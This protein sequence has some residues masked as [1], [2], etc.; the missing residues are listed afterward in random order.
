MQGFYVTA[1]LIGLGF[2][3]MG[4][5]DPL[6]DSFVPL[7][8]GDYI[9]SKGL[10]GT[11]MTL[12]NLFALFLIPFVSALSDRTRTSIGRRMPW[13]VVTLPLTAI[14]FATVPFAAGISLAALIASLF[15]LN[16]FK[17]AARGPVVALMPDTI[18]GE[19]RSEA[20]G[21]INTMAG[22]AAIVGTVGLSKLMDVS[23][24]LPLVGNTSRRLPFLLAGVLVVIATVLLFVFIKE[25]SR[26]GGSER[27]EPVL[28]SIRAVLTGGDESAIFILPALLFWFFG[29]Q[30]I[31]PFLTMYTRDFLGVSEGTAGLSPGMFAVSYAIFAI[32]SGIVA[33]RAGRGRT[34]RFS[35]LVISVVCLLLFAHEPASKLL[36]F[37][38]NAALAS[39]WGLLFAMGAFW[40]A[41]VTNSFPMLWQM[42]TYETMG[43][44]TG[45]YYTFSQ[46][47]AILSPPVTGTLIDVAG[48]RSIFL[49]GALCMFAAAMIMRRVKRGE[50]DPPASEHR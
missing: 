7:F 25:K 14:F 21:V 17:Q 45:L 3:T 40:V 13:I 30:G 42:A 12:D 19:L 47:A 43:I 34:I 36:G 9:G 18:P 33:H 1:G 2:F 38:R 31:L 8:L 50:A 4:L 39:F 11:I 49:F 46:A 22:I 20:N 16:V 5:M 48:F 24:V 29:Y 44:Y 37:G 32:P 15:L 41:V 27:R 26:D 10:I 28:K 23:I 35:L 6:Y